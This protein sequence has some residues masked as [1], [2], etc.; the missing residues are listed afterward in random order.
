MR[1]TKGEERKGKKGKRVCS[2]NQSGFVEGLRGLG[3][4]GKVLRFLLR[5]MVI[6][7]ESSGLGCGW[8]TSQTQ[9]ALQTQDLHLKAPMRF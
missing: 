8:G 4:E 5:N 6:K 9:V 2:E 3:A 7:E 1:L